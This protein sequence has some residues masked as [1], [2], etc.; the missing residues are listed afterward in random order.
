MTIK[1]PNKDKIKLLSS[2]DVYGVMQR[3]LL[4]EQ[5]VDQDKEHFWMI[6]LTMNSRILYI[7][8]VSMGS[9]KVTSVEP[10]NVYRWAVQKGAVK[11]IFVHN[12]PSG[13]LK[14]SEADLDITDRLIQVGRILNIEAIDHLIISKKSYLSF[15]DSQIF[16]KLKE[17]TK[18]VP[19][20]ELIKRI[21]DEEKKIREEAVRDAEAKA[22]VKKVKAVKAAQAEAEIKKQEELKEA[23]ERA[24]VEK[25]KSVKEA[26]EKGVKAA[27]AAEELGVKAVKATKLE[28]A[29][30]LKKRNLPLKEIIAIS[31]LTKAEIEKIK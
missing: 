6:G 27:K 23:E 3:I 2:D 10:M 21:K 28:V 8:L 16:E 19:Q 17:S 29:K 13:E 18:W 25:L 20:F 4:S 30:Q 22:E 15:A 26:L 11:V 31:G 24:E 1:I 9:V 7:E 5:K 14:P 12:H